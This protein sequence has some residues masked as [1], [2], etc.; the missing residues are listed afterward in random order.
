MIILLRG[1]QG[2]SDLKISPGL[3]PSSIIPRLGMPNY[4]EGQK[5]GHFSAPEG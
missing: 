2:K 1:I 3:V 4:E 5:K